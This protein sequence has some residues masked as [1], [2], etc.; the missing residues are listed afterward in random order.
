MFCFCLLRLGLAVTGAPAENFGTRIHGVKVEGGGGGGSGGGGGGGAGSQTHKKTNG[1][2]RRPPDWRKY[3]LLTEMSNAQRAHTIRYVCT[4]SREP[5]VLCNQTCGTSSSALSC[6]HHHQHC[7]V[8]IISALSCVHHHQHCLV[9][10]I[11]ALSCVHHQ[12]CLEK[13]LDCCVG[14]QGERPSFVFVASQYVVCLIVSPVCGDTDPMSSR[15]ANGLTQA[16]LAKVKTP[17]WNANRFVSNN[18][19]T[20]ETNN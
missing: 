4:L 3:N 14:A 17:V 12:H 1:R 11:S 13:R 18:Y 7:L 20:P 16:L 15:A 9:Y 2:D 6:V 19:S 5:L 10:I 8:Y